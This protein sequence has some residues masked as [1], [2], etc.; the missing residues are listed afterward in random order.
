MGRIVQEF[1]CARSG[2]GC[3]GYF[4]AKVNTDLDGIHNIICPNCKHVHQRRIKSGHI[5]DD[6][7]FNSKPVDEIY[8]TKS[9]FQMSPHTKS[10]QKRANTSEERKSVIV[11]SPDELIKRE[12][13]VSIF[14]Q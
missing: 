10:M 2:D 6:G 13:W 3:G 11:T 8:A 5:T 12:M 14:G 4:L 9:S 7:R 1:Y